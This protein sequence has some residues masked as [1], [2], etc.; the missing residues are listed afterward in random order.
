[1]DA[2][3]DPLQQKIAENE[4]RYSVMEKL[5]FLKPFWIAAD[6]KW[7]ARLMLGGVL[8]LTAVEISLTGSI[9]FGFQAALNALAAKNAAAFAV[10][11]VTTLAEIGAFA[12]VCSGRDWVALNLG[13]NW[14]GWLSNQFSEAWLNGKTYL[15]LQHS[16]NYGQSP[17]YR[18]AETIQVV[19][20]QAVQLS[21]ALFRAVAGL[22]TFSVLLWHIS[23][24]MV[25]AAVACASVAHVATHWTGGTMGKLMKGVLD[26]DAKF[27]QALVRVRDNAKP[28]ALAGLESVE[29]ETLRDEFN[30]MDTKRREFYKVN[31]RTG[32]LNI[33][34]MSSSNVVPIALTA[35]KFF[36]GVATLGSLELARQVYSQF[37][38]ALNWF[39]QGYT[40]IISWSTNVNQLMDFKKDLDENKLDILRQAP[41]VAP[42]P[43][44]SMEIKP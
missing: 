10:S 44:P 18:I 34:N 40:T 9:A 38:N 36:A 43:K 26:A 7:K 16:K 8:T 13:Q 12:L 32:L 24:L 19:T 11:G 21:L 17:D 23:P 42:F 15:R 31:F 37:Y 39:P 4:S 29:K 5:R 3:N 14:R 30:N 33:F 28:I 22:A 41:P 20:T 25:G 2:V 1:M 6:Q 27:R 35:P